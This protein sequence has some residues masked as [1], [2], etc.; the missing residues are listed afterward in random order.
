MNNGNVWTSQFTGE[1]FRVFELDKGDSG[2]LVWYR[3][4]VIG[5]LGSHYIGRGVSRWTGDGWEIVELTVN[6]L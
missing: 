5:D 6:C 3:F 1:Q 2:Y 4:N